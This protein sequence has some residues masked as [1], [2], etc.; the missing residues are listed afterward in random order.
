MNI[1]YYQ[2]YKNVFK[3]FFDTLFSAF[4]LILISPIFL[5]ISLI[6]IINFKGSPF[7]LQ[8]RPGLN[9]KLFVIIK[10]KTMNDKKNIKGELMKDEF[11]LTKI[12]G[13]IRKVSLDEIPQLIN[14]FKGN[15]SLVGPRPLLPE[16]LSLYNKQQKK[17]HN[18]K[19]GMTGLAQV[20]GRNLISWKEKLELDVEYVKNQSLF[21]DL[22]ILFKTIFKVFKI[23]EINNYSKNSVEKF[24]GKN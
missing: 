16:Y 21:L 5:F 8:K 4:L 3:F 1:K 17:R 2:M 18:V 11:R 9:E 7:F 20:S 24:N 15:M 10:F 12:G 6:L 22:N 13:L 23:K 14:V 19:P